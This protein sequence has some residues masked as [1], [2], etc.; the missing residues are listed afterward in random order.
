VG[1]L[2]PAGID[3][4]SPRFVW[5]RRWVRQEVNHGRVA[6]L[7]SKNEPKDVES[8]FEHFE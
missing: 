4:A 5:A 8:V 6:V 7:V 3:V 2:G 1:E